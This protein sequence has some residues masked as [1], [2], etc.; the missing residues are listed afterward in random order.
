MLHISTEPKIV[1][2]LL[3]GNLA[4]TGS[5]RAGE[6]VPA[7]CLPSHA[8]NAIINDGDHT[9]ENFC[10]GEGD[11][12]PWFQVDMIGVYKVYSV[13]CSLG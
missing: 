6:A 4:A 1:Y 11:V 3:N 12:T 13:S 2:A 10:T 5:S 9:S 8:I 7:N